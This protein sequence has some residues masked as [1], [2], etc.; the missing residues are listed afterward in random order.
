[1][2]WESISLESDG[3]K[4]IRAADLITQQRLLCFL[5]RHPPLPQSGLNPLSETPP[6]SPT[7]D[8]LTWEMITLITIGELNRVVHL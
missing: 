7:Q 1:M 6:P 2:G 4:M 3:G 8:S 5:E